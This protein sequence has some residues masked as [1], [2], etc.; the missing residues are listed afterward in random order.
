MARNVV[1]KTVIRLRTKLPEG[2]TPEDIDATVLS[3]TMIPGALMAY[4]DGKYVISL[5]NDSI[6]TSQDNP[7][8]KRVKFMQWEEQ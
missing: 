5:H 3:T 2:A 8:A 1:E 7:R 4:H 6:P